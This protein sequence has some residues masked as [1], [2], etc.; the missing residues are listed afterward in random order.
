MRQKPAKAVL[1]LLLVIF[2]CLLA[3]CSGSD[4]SPNVEGQGFLA[5]IWLWF[6]AIF[7]L[8][9]PFFWV[10][11]IGVFA[12]VCV[13][14]ESLEVRPGKA[15]F[16][17]IV[18]FVLFLLA[19]EPVKGFLGQ[20]IWWVVASPFIYIVAGV[21]WGAYIK[22]PIF[23][24]RWEWKMEEIVRIYIRDRDL[25]DEKG[26]LLTRIPLSHQH[27][28]R[29]FLVQQTG[30]SR[31]EAP[32][33]KDHKQ[34]I[35]TWCIYWPWS[36]LSTLLRDLIQNLVEWCLEFVRSDLER[37]TAS[38]NRRKMELFESNKQQTD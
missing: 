11:T 7:A 38:A 12:L 17:L 1:S 34:R 2:F 22:W 6:L 32:N 20:H 35:I 28:F 30:N 27:T 8:S 23:V 26:E 31:G 14:V 4:S 24:K 16:S 3:A 9:N 13:F 21:F 5:G 18:L 10:I 19:N 33:W 37:R 29:D 25:R 15:G 36:I